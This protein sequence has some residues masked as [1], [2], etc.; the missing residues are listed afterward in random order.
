MVTI[1]C[2]VSTVCGVFQ[3]ITSDFEAGKFT[4]TLK[5]KHYHACFKITKALLW[6][7]AKI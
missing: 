3:C 7:I 5:G 2:L 1:I 4:E 6:L